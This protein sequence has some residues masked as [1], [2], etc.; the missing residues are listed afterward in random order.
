MALIHLN[1]PSRYLRG[2]TDVNI[3][4][5]DR[6]EGAGIDEFYRPGEKY[7]VLWLLHGGM[8][9]YTDWVRKTRLET[10]LA[11][12]KLM[13]VMP[14]ALNSSYCDWPHFGGGY[15]A[16]EYLIRELMPMIYA[17]FP[18]SDRREE[19]FIA[20][21]S[22][23]GHGAW[24]MAF[25]YPDRFAACASLSG[26][27][28]DFAARYQAEQ[29]SGQRRH[30]TDLVEMHGGLEGLLASRENTRGAAEKTAREGRTG[31]LPRLYAAAG[32]QDPHVCE[33]RNSV[34]FLQTL[35]I[36]VTYAETPGFA[37]EWP[38]WD[39]AIADA[40]RFFGFSINRK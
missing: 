32:D 14:S 8:G 16:H 17:W 36:S 27:M 38:F 26:A 24:K 29:A 12:T 20:G 37:H 10:Y 15:Y 5:P 11:G 25:N 1:F 22:M 39:R 31:S 18:A 2:N 9:D 33:M 6:P 34:S 19:N 21:L 35:G 3:L 28:P 13:A 23:G 4:L 30:I 7:P 40:L